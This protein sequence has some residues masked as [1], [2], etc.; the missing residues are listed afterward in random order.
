MPEMTE[1]KSY[2]PAAVSPAALEYEQ[3]LKISEQINQGLSLEE[4]LNNVFESFLAI[5]PYDRIGFALIEPEDT[6]GPQVCAYWARSRVTEPK[7]SKNYKAP[8]EGSSL[9]SI[10]TTR[11]P[12]IINNLEEYARQRPASESSRLI[13]EEGI[14]SSLTCPLI[15]MNKEFGFIFFSSCRVGTYDNRHTEIFRLIANQLAMALLKA[16]LY[17]EIRR[18]DA[19]KDRLLGIASHDM[20]NPLSAIQMGIQMMQK[21]MFGEFKEPHR[22]V[23]NSMYRGCE[24]IKRLISDFLDFGSIKSGK[25]V[26]SPQEVDWKEY[27]T[28]ICENAQ[29][30]VSAKKIA[31]NFEFEGPSGLIVLD[32]DRIATVVTNLIVNATKFSVEGTTITVKGSR[33]ESRALCSVEDQGQGIAPEE[34]HKL[35]KEFGKTRTVPTAGEKSTG[36]GL[37]ITRSLV[38]AHGGTVNVKS[39]LGRGSTFSFAIPI[40]PIRSSR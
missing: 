35:F 3:I 22:K 31:L 33:S 10:L 25:L 19:L 7:L 14:R 20:K 8:L 15:A 36:L 13:L 12:R 39:E 27:L 2:Q 17:E 32:C 26:L 21:G 23:L 30:Q 16:R 4:I 24:T 28:E 1:F 11:E 34:L 38:E 9:K 37:Y 5:I 6:D 40:R 29:M 18:S